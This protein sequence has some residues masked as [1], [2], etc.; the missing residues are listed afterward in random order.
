MAYEAAAKAL[1]YQVRIMLV[2]D[3]SDPV[4]QKLCTERNRHGVPLTQIRRMAKQFED[5]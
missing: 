3:P 1:G 2:G 5:C 4:H